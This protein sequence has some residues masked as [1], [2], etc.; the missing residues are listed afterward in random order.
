MRDD[1]AGAFVALSA[2]QAA[3]HGLMLS[4]LP[5]TTA[6]GDVAAAV[7]SEG[8]RH[9]LVPVPVGTPVVADRHSRSVTLQRREL[10]VD[11]ERRF[12]IDV[13][14]HEPEL[15]DLFERLA[16]DMC[17][18]ISAK[19]SDFLL[20][21]A[22]TLVRWRRLFETGREPLSPGQL[23]GVFGELWVLREMVAVD[24]LRRVD[25][26]KGPDNA[27]HDFRRGRIAVEVK[28]ST[29]RNGRL[30]EIHG[31]EQLDAAPYEKLALAYIRLRES[32]DGMR[33]SDLLTELRE[34]GVDSVELQRRLDALGV[35]DDTDTPSY[36]VHEET[37]FSVTEDFP[38]IV[39]GSFKTGVVPEGVQ[40]LNYR[41]D[42]TGPYPPPMEMAA[43]D[44]LLKEIAAS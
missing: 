41:L 36:E 43:R 28:T 17:E 3:A 8:S 6:V 39:P 27:I 15:D 1:I 30:V 2:S 38:K 11:G 24:P 13:A 4:Q 18:Q 10:I 12:F 34:A 37:W 9:L 32:A 29:A 42:L 19:P 26:W 5:V 33:L 25:H 40:S 21:P 31:A 23:A 22:R 14:C 7:D 44:D 20:I 16:A 35:S